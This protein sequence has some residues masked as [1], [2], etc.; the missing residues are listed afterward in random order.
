[1]RHPWSPSILPKG[2]MMH[3]G[4]GWGNDIRRRVA[5]CTLVFAALG[6]TGA[7]A[8]TRSIGVQGGAMGGLGMRADITF[9]HF[10]QDLPLSLRV[11]VGFAGCD[12]G[13]PLAA[14]RVFI[15]NNTNGTPEESGHIWQLRLDFVHPFTQIAGAP[16]NLG[17]G[18]RKARFTGTFNY[19]GGNENFDVTGSPWGVG[20]LLDTNFPIGKA[21]DFVVAAG[22]DYYFSADLEGHDTTYSPDGTTVNPQEDYTWDDA[23]AAINQPGWE[24]QLLI[25][26]RWR[27]K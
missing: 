7:S 22:L 9:H 15:N 23:D 21:T 26:L 16:V 20:V 4:D 14:R 1:M 18:I 6:A 13:D 8:T 25:G 27:L 5:I 24:P 19:V 11:G 3:E 12:A 10:T 17:V 2:E